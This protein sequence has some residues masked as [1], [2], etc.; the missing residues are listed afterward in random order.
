MEGN[1]RKSGAGFG[2]DTSFGID[3]YHINQD[4]WVEGSTHTTQKI[5]TVEAQQ[6]KR[7]E[8]HPSRTWNS[9]EKDKDK[10]SGG[11]NCINSI[12]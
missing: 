8:T 9:T 2:R 7:A 10:L 5:K 11:A 4:S 3:P 12:E 6:T 1:K